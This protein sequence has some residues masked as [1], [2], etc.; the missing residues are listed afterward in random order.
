M[1]QQKEVVLSLP[2]FKEMVD[3]IQKLTEVIDKYEK[4]IDA[5]NVYAESENKEKG[6]D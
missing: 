4:I 6:N 3:Y 1:S 2:E 5:Y